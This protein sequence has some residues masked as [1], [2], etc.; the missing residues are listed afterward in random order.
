VLSGVEDREIYE[1]V[2]SDRRL[3]QAEKRQS[4]VIAEGGGG[5][6]TGSAKLVM[7]MPY[8]L[9]DHGAV[10]VGFEFGIE[11]NTKVD[12]TVNDLDGVEGEGGEGFTETPSKIHVSRA[13][14]LEFGGIEENHDFTFGGRKSHAVLEAPEL[15]SLNE[16]KK[17]GVGVCNEAEVIDEKKNT[18]EESDEGGEDWDGEMWENL[19]EGPNKVGDVETPK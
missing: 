6:G 10:I 13:H 14:A 1:G 19:L 7:G 8:F 3:P 15:G 4:G 9:D 12:E 11:G 16:P 5:G 18:D 17:L 2:Y